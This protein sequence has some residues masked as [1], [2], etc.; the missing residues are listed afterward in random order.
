MSPEEVEA[1]FAED[2]AEFVLAQ[3][4]AGLDFFSDG[5]L[6]WQDIF[7]P[8]V[9]ATAGLEART[10]VRWFD[11]NSFFRAPELVG[12]LGLAKPVPEVYLGD[13]D[14]PV[15]RVATLPSPYAFS[16][17]TQA[18]T[19]RTDLIGELTREVLAPVVRAVAARGYEVIHLQE[20]WLA[21]FGI[22]DEDWNPF[23]KALTDL[24]NAAGD[25]TLVLHLYFGDAGPHADRLRSLPVD[26]LGIDF[27]E[28]DPASLGSQWE[29]GLLAGCIDGR[30][31]L[32]ESVDATVAFVK[33]ALDRTGARELYV[34][35]S[36]ELELL[37]R[38]L[39]RTKV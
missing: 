21:Y 17:A 5:L 15:P 11:N 31:S 29:L 10:L 23:E 6:R 24:R 18:T 13:E 1:A 12:Q 27:L 2:R 33:E 3:Q 8:L 30:S 39:A 14:L 26:V 38:D 16:R 36:A 25:R 34:S 32:V 19:S 20:P 35:S 37:P 9:D 22:D 4:D 28:T 7:R